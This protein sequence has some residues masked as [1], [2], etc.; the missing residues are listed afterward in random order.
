MLSKDFIKSKY[1]RFKDNFKENEN[2]F[3]NLYF[4]EEYD[5]NNNMI[6]AIIY[7]ES[8]E[9]AYEFIVNDSNMELFEFIDEENVIIENEKQRL[10]EWNKEENVLERKRKCEEFNLIENNKNNNFKIIKPN[11]KR[12]TKVLLVGKYNKETYRFFKKR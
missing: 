9:D 5:L 6:K 1:F 12:H 7:S 4:I 8:E 10:I 3:S 11:L 2:F